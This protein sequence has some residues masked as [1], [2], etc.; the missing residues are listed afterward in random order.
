MR[1]WMAQREFQLIEM[2]YRQLLKL[3][4]RIAIELVC[5]QRLLQPAGHLIDLAVPG[6]SG[7]AVGA[8]ACRAL[9]TTILQGL[10]PTLLLPA[11]TRLMD[12]NILMLA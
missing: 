5:R 10:T 11:L 9:C 12:R 7:Q 3:V 4:L 1:R 8:F 6:H 2:L